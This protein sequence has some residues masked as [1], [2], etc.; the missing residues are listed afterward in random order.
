MK[1]RPRDHLCA[2]NDD[3]YPVFDQSRNVN[4]IR[5]E[6]WPNRTYDSVIPIRG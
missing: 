4:I 3:T 1:D 2:R 5:S 6:T